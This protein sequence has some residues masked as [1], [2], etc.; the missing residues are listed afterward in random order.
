MIQLL[1][2][3]SFHEGETLNKKLYVNGVEYKP[4]EYERLIPVQ[5]VP[6]GHLGWM[7]DGVD[8]VIGDTIYKLHTRA[9]TTQEYEDL[10]R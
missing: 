1:K 8:A 10:S 9:E 5:E 3:F 2:Q 7:Y 4:N 6:K